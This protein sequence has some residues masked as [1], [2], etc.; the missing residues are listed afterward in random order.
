MRV[1]RPKTGVLSALAAES[2]GWAALATEKGED[3]TKAASVATAPEAGSGAAARG[4]PGLRPRGI[5]CS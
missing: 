1:K 5:C 4:T 2:S 3:D